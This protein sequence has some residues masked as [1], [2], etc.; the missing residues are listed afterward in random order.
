MS[1]P[2]TPNPLAEQTLGIPLTQVGMIERTIHAPLVRVWENV[3]DWEHLP[4]LHDTSFSVCALQDAGPWGW[5]AE[6]RPAGDDGTGEPGIVELVTDHEAGHY[7][8]RII[9]GPTKGME[10]WTK[11][12]DKGEVTDIEV[13]FLA[14]EI[15]GIA[16]DVMG[17]IMIGVYT[18]LWDEDEQMMRDRHAALQ[19]PRRGG[20]EIP[21]GKRNALTLPMTVESKF[22]PVH[23][24]E[25]EGELIAWLGVC[26]HLLG[27]LDHSCRKGNTVTCP[28]HGYSFDIDSGQ[29]IGG[30]LKIKATCRIVETADGLEVVIEA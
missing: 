4:H 22:G 17:Q 12:I 13:R 24:D 25:V 28:W 21:L 2:I 1:T 15:D 10:I 14:P 3:H 29:E 30:D 27:P 9:D 16:G 5:R 18:Q 6:T 26:P 19:R 8:S 7:V 20:G 23:V 11:L